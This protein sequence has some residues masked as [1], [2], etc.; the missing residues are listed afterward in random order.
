ML[1]GVIMAGG[2][3]TRLWPLSRRG[4]EK[5]FQEVGGSSLLVETFNRIQKAIP[6]SR[7]YVVTTQMQRDSVAASLGDE[8]PLENIVAEP[9][10][11][12]TLAALAYI[13]VRLARVDA[14]PAIVAFPSDHRIA[15]GDGFIKTLGAGLKFLAKNRVFVVFGIK[16]KSP[17]TRYGYIV[18][19]EKQKTELGAVFKIDRFTEKPGREVA[20]ELI[21]TGKAYW[22]SGIFAFRVKHLLDSMKRL[23]P[24]YYEAFVKIGDSIGSR[25]EEQTTYSLYQSLEPLSF[26]VGIMEKTD[27]AVVV[28]AEFEW[29]D[30]GVFDSLASSLSEVETNR[31]EGDFIGLDASNNIAITDEGLVAVLG[32]SDIVVVRDGDVVLVASKRRLEDLRLLT[33]HLKERNLEKYL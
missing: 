2:M 28:T 24:E 19:G 1:Y 30:I 3:G 13:S 15:D 9:I 4:R 12:G 10:G 6:P 8:L 32:L 31:V 17:I 33:E 20:E 29:S 25:E 5:Q 23:T 16:P 7:V 11:K 27:E 18:V 26:D 21:A 14:E 22:N